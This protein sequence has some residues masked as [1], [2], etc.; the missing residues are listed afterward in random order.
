MGYTEEGEAYEWGEINSGLASEVINAQPN[1]SNKQSE[2]VD[3]IVKPQIISFPRRIA[4][5]QLSCGW[6]HC[7]CLSGTTCA[8]TA[9]KAC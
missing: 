2:Q 5:K 9:L 4:I 7:L 6:A 8:I 3:A 1:K